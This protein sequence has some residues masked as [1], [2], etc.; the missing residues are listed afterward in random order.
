MADESEDC[1]GFNRLMIRYEGSDSTSK[2]IWRVNRSDGFLTV[3][4]HPV[5]NPKYIVQIKRPE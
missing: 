2:K 3:R 5:N 4:T 1:R